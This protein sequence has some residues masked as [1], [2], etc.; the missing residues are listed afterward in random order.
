MAMQQ[1]ELTSIRHMTLISKLLNM[2]CFECVI[3]KCFQLI[4]EERG[5][6][7]K[8][9]EHKPYYVP[10]CTYTILDHPTPS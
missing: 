9:N 10:N 4:S 3:W 6:A 5:A 2:K 8:C 7:P 1:N